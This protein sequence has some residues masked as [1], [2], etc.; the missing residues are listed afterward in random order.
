MKRLFKNQMKLIKSLQTKKGRE[1]N[2]LFTVEGIKSVNELLSSGINTKYLVLDNDFDH[3][4]FLK[5]N[6]FSKDIEVFNCDIDSVSAMRSSE[7]ILAV[8]EIPDLA[9]MDDF[10]SVNNNLLGLFGISDPGNLGTLLRTACWFGF[11]G[12]VL[13][14]DCADVYSQ[15]VIRGSMGAVF[16]LNIL[17]AKDYRDT[18]AH[19]KNWNKVGTFLDIENNFGPSNDKKIILFLGNESSGLK[20]EMKEYT[21]MNFRIGSG[22]GFD[23]LNVSVAGGIIMHELFGEGGLK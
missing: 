11:D 18:A 15:K 10:F 12:A 2:G 6:K 17:S 14:E 3:G 4:S 21:D 19:L 23:S 7:G 1:E 13:Y 20:K 9:D 8:A 22:S 5:N 16:S